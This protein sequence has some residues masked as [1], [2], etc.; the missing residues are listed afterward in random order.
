NGSSIL[1]STGQTGKAHLPNLLNYSAGLDFGLLNSLSITGD[2]LAQTFFSANRVFTGSRLGAPDIS[3]SPSGAL[4]CQP[5]TFTT[6]L[7]ALGAKQIAIRNFLIT[8]NV[9]VKLDHNGLHFKPAPMIG[10]S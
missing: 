1:A 2:F 5:Q 6:K 10:I 9:L 8:E 3:C 7:F 4:T